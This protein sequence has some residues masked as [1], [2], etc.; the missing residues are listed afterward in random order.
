[1]KILLIAAPRPDSNQTEMHTGDSRPPMGL[2]YIS[3]YNEHC[4]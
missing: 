1:M 2:A 3:A 4:G